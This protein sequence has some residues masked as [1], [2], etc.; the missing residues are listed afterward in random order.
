MTSQEDNNDHSP[1][2]SCNSIFVTVGTTLFE[3]LIKVISDPRFL[4]I[5]SKRNY[6][7]LT[8]QYG[9]GTYEPFSSLSSFSSTDVSDKIKC[10]SYRFK[11]SLDPDMKQASLII[12]HAGAGSI[13]EGL[14]QCRLRLP[15]CKLI[16]VINSKLMNNHQ[17]ELAHALESRGHLICVSDPEKLL[18]EDNI[19]NQ[20]ID[21]WKGKPF[22]QGDDGLDFATLVDECMDFS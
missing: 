1:S 4:K 5:V 16:V 14:T 9:K 2:N 10:E 20:I 7:H 21:T 19:W 11:P 17:T 8:I 13:M 12:S 22:P 15:N 6:N 18:D 3:P